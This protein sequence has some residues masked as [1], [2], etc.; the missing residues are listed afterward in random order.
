[1]VMVMV[2]VRLKFEKDQFTSNSFIRAC[3][4]Y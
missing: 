3:E 4:S 1:M 2:V